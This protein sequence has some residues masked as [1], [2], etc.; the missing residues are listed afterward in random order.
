[1]AEAAAAEAADRDPFSFDAAERQRNRQVGSPK[2][3]SGASLGKA[4]LF[5]CASSRPQSEP[6]PRLRGEGCG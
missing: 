3:A 1:M 2:Y 4:K 6:L 5:V